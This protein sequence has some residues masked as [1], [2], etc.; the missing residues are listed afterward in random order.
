MGAVPGIRSATRTGVVIAV[1]LVL[2]A[3]RCYGIAVRST[4]YTIYAT[5]DSHARDGIG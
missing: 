4:A 5:L 3:M 2:D 1:S